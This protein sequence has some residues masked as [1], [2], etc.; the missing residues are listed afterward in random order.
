MIKAGNRQWHRF[1]HPASLIQGTGEGTV[2]GDILTCTTAGTFYIRSKQAYGEWEFE[3]NKGADVNDTVNKFIAGTTIITD[4]NGYTVRFSGTE[5]VSFPRGNPS[6]DY[7]FYSPTNYINVNTEYTIKVA[8]L[9][10]AGVFKDIPGAGG[11]V[12]YPAN[13]FVVFIKG[14]AFGTSAWTLVDVTGG[15]GTNPVTDSTCNESEYYV[16]N[17][18]VGDKIG[19]TK[20][21]NWN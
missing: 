12:I 2:S 6:N 14:G 20:Y 18:D 15:I 17:L 3:V 7:L 5:R 4:E 10:S 21:K 1:I 13:T 19:I 8:R 9:S 16:A 11:A